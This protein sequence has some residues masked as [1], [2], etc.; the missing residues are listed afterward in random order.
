MLVI[1]ENISIPLSEIEFSAVRAEGPG[2][3]H[4]NKTSSAIHLRFNIEKSSLP[5]WV[6]FRLLNEIKDNKIKPS[7]EIIIKAQETRSLV[8]NKEAAL[9][10]LKDLI[11]KATII[12]KRRRA[13]K[14]SKSSVN[15]RLD[16]KK[17]HGKKKEGRK[18]VKLD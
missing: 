6:K 10:R 3:Q 7:G 17:N 18:K 4:V 12:E 11:L 14:P 1:N 15:K 8:R 9:K 2:G 13:T 5:R 16:S